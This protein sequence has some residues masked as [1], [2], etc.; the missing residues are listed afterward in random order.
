MEVAVNIL[1]KQSQTTDKGWSP[2]WGFG[3]ELTT[4]HCENECL[5]RNIYR[6]SLGHELIFWYDLSNERG[7][8]FRKWDVGVWTGLGWLRIETGGKQL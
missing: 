7:W 4:P 8:I 1:N 6:Q 5:L 3:E 2:D